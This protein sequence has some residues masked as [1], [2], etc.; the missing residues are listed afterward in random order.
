MI[1][2]AL[3]YV[4]GPLSVCQQVSGRNLC[5]TDD[6]FRSVVK[7]LRTISVIALIAGIIIVV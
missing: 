3:R 1:A 6:E 4:V 2:F 7:Y 5:M